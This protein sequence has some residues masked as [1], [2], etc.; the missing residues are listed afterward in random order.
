[1][2][3][4][5]RGQGSPHSPHLP[6]GFQPPE[7]LGSCNYCARGGCNCTAQGGGLGTGGGPCTVT[8]LGGGMGTAMHWSLRHWGATGRGSSRN[9]PHSV[10][11]YQPSG[12]PGERAAGGGGGK[13]CGDAFLCPP[14]LA[15]RPTAR[16]GAG[17]AAGRGGDA[18][19]PRRADGAATAARHPA[20][21]RGP[22]APASPGRTRAF[23]GKS[24]V[25]GLFP[26]LQ[27]RGEMGSGC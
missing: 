22:P 9:G 21:P 1:M 18:A 23:H 15:G 5:D 17:P 7:P 13:P 3:V 24:R 25:P 12:I 27:R 11:A 19:V 26:G 14:R 4:G 8:A 2:P 10:P 20:A 6:L 16:G